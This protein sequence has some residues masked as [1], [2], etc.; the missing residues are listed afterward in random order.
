M[1]DQKHPVN[2]LFAKAEYARLV[3]RAADLTLKEGRRVSVAELVRRLAMS[4]Q[5]G[6]HEPL[7]ESRAGADSA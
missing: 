7:E 4:N 2:V 5:D 1:P 3:R 6:F